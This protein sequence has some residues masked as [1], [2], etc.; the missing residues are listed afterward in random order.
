[1]ATSHI[2]AEHLVPEIREGRV[3]VLPVDLVDDFDRFLSG[4]P[5][6]GTKLD[7]RQ[8]SGVSLNIVALG[9]SA[10][11]EELQSLPLGGHE[12][13]GV[14]YAAG[15]AGLL[16]TP[17]YFCK[18]LDPLFWKAPGPRYVFAVQVLGDSIAPIFRAFGE[19]DGRETLRVSTD[20]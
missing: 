14:A 17:T 3:R 5:V 8:I 10:L 16:V 18:N 2:D 11:L 4:F 19:Y 1:M 15:Q 6:L 20:V 12:M 7:W 13:I 9:P